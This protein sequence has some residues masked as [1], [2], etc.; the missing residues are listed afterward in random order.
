[1]VFWYL[2]R[3]KKQLKN[4][5]SLS[6]LASYGTV[7]HFRSKTKKDNFDIRCV[8]IAFETSEKIG[9]NCLAYDFLFDDENQP[10]IAEVSY[11]F[12]QE[13]YDGCTGYWDKKLIW[14]EGKFIP[15]NW[16]VD[17]MIEEINSKK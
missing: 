16:M 2:L 14:R 4:K 12:S 17:D 6:I 5:T 15:Q 9:S 11:G 1:M 8:Q 13:G 7:K 10:L 3:V